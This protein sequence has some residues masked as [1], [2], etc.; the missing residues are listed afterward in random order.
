MKRETQ[1]DH[2]LN[3]P[4]PNEPGVPALPLESGFHFMAW[5]ETG[6]LTI[7]EWHPDVW[8]WVISYLGAFVD[9]EELAHLR[10]IG[11]IPPPRSRPTWKRPRLPALWQ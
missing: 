6:V 8:C 1:M 2:D 10:Y 9:A 7:G 11:P 3:W 4:N 5:P